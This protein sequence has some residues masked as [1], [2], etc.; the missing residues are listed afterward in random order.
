MYIDM[1]QIQQLNGQLEAK[2]KEIDEIRAELA[3]KN[4]E[5]NEIRAE[6]AAK[7]NGGE[8]WWINGQIRG[9]GKGES[10]NEGKI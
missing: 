5:N 7:N 2:N 9:K 10:S 3:A 1:Q 6:L 4:N 8:E